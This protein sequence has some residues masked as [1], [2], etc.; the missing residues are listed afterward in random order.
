[1]KSGFG[2]GTG[3]GAP[4]PLGTKKFWKGDKYMNYY[5][6]G[7]MECIFEAKP[8][9]YV[10]L[11]FLYKKGVVCIPKEDHVAL[12]YLLLIPAECSNGNYVSTNL[13]L[14]KHYYSFVGKIKSKGVKLVQERIAKE[15]V[16]VA[17]ILAEKETLEKKRIE[18][19]K[20]KVEEEKIDSMAKIFTGKGSMMANKRLFIEYK[21]LS[22]SKEF[23]NTK[24]TIK[25]DNMYVWRMVFDIL[26]FDL[27]KELKLDFEKIKQFSKDGTGGELEFEIIYSENFPFDPPFIRIVRPRFQFHTGHI[28]VGGSICMEILTKSGW[29]V[30][31]SMENLFIDILT[32]ICLGGGR[33]DMTNWNAQYTLAEAKEAFMRVAKDH[34][35]A[36]P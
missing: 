21:G 11:G 12:R 16:K 9:N 24:I 28:T 10:F 19:L 34:G 5:V 2:F 3:Y 35:W 14:A 25:E 18:E 20:M 8:G 33:I 1:M 30:A 17:K 22:T 15:I 13:N 4:V 23:K 26:K 29:T 27:S 6:M 36:K 31:I 7:I 32:T